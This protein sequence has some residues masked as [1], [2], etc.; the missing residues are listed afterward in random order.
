MAAAKLKETTLVSFYT[1]L[2]IEFRVYEAT[3]GA[4]VLW[5]FSFFY[6][7]QIDASWEDSAGRSAVGQ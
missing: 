5:D 3:P 2:F 6:W 1:L 4:H 7:D